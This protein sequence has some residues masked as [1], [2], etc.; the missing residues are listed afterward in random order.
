VG[1]Q[2][3]TNMR[4]DASIL[5]L[6]AWLGE[7]TAF[8]GDYQ[9]SMPPTITKSVATNNVISFTYP[10]ETHVF[11]VTP[12]EIPAVVKWSVL[13]GQS[14]AVKNASLY[15]VESGK[16]RVV[17]SST[18]TPKMDHN[19]SPVVPAETPDP[20][21]DLK[22]AAKQAPGG[23]FSE[24]LPETSEQSEKRQAEPSS[25]DLPFGPR[26]STGSVS[27]NSSIYKDQNVLD[28]KLFLALEWIID[29]KKG[30]SFTTPFAVSEHVGQV[31]PP[32][33]LAALVSE[34]DK[35]DQS[36]PWRREGHFD[37]TDPNSNPPVDV[38]TGTGLGSPS[39]PATAASSNDP[40]A[41][42]AASSSSNDSSKSEAGEGDNNKTSNNLPS[43]TIAGIVV[44]AVIGGLLIISALAY[45]LC[46]RRRSSKRHIHGDIGYASDSGAA[47]IIAREKDMPGVNHS[48]S[49]AYADD[50]GHLHNHGGL[51]HGNETTNYSNQEGRG[52][53]GGAHHQSRDSLAQNDYSIYNNN[54]N[55]E[56]GIASNRHSAIGVA[57][58]GLGDQNSAA[59]SRRERTR[60]VGGVPAGRTS[61]QTS[62]PA[63][64]A[65]SP[66]RYAH[67]I[68]EGMTE[69]EI[70]RL[71]DE[72][73]QL[74]A[75]IEDAGRHGGGGGRPNK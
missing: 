61:H 53:V 23:M 67:L 35:Y 49:S 54:S 27:I 26:G 1:H 51:D 64:E 38:N 39:T 47:G 73:R 16:E 30:R 74:D 63:S 4:I 3:T 28:K 50:N 37:G 44:G 9:V 24:F 19:L 21:H 10:S 34:L 40:F 71:E 20:V 29:G 36:T 45:F 8:P 72:E 55:A 58:S 68:E 33:N 13:G 59:E 42:P 5:G 11:A 17:A 6:A 2:D 12:G 22:K 46:F 69:D 7:A 31:P 75:A 43:G 60:S 57:T 62:R 18:P 41:V 48:P 65:R 66:S 25:V 15:V 70:R 56:Q 14:F 52:M 32:G